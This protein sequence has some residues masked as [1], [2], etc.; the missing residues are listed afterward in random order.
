MILEGATAT[1][2]LVDSIHNHAWHQ[3]SLGGRAVPEA[4]LDARC[5]MLNPGALGIWPEVHRALVDPIGGAVPQRD[6]RVVVPSPVAA[7]QEV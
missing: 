6:R 1:F 5:S 3:G 2:S 4:R 7:G